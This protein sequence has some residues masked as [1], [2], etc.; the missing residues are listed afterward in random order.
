[1][2]IARRQFSVKT[3]I[4]NVI[5]GSMGAAAG[6]IFSLETGH[7]MVLEPHNLNLEILSSQLFG[8]LLVLAIGDI[9]RRNSG[10]Y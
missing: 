4:G 5:L 10:R 3:V 6:T 8:S 2:C 7:R 9:Y 1:M